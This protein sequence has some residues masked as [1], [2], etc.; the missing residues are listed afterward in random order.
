[1]SSLLG[2]LSLFL[3]ALTFTAGSAF[4]QRGFSFT[5]HVYGVGLVVDDVEDGDRE[6]GGGLGLRVGLGLSKSVSLYASL[7]G[8]RVESQGEVVRVVR[9]LPDGDLGRFDDNY[10]LASGEFG[11]QFNILPSGV[12]NPFIRTGFRG[13]TV[14]LD[15]EGRD[16]DEDPQLRGGGLTVGGGVE[17]RLSPKLAIEAALEGTGGT[18]SEFETDDIRYRNFEDIEFGEGRVSVGLVWRPNAKSRDRDRR[19]HRRGNRH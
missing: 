12:V 3:F 9:D 11:A 7:G 5:P 4:A 15:A 8:A 13:Q 17:V 16:L 19:R 6:E 10:T 18:F 14:V 1:M 2:R